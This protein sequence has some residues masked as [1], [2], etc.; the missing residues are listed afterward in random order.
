MKP[1]GAIRGRFR[2]QFPEEGSEQDSTSKPHHTQLKQA[3][4]GAF[5]IWGPF[6]R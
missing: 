2:G 3:Y 6:L 4:L 1:S 5:A